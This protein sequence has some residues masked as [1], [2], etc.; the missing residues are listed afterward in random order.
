MRLEY[1][2][3]LSSSVKPLIDLPLYNYFLRESNPSANS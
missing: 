1:D 2:Q 3:C